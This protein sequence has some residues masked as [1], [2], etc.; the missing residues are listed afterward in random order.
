MLTFAIRRL[1]Q[2]VV[3]LFIMSAL[4]F[5]AVYA[6]GNPI[7]ILINPQADQAEIAAATK[8]LGLDQPLW[9]Q[10]RNFIVGAF[11]G[12]F[13]KSFSANIPGSQWPCGLTIGSP[14]VCS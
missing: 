5:A 7:D 12:D 14:C 10:Y 1:L 8:A 4:V 6:I 13:G 11:T 2:S 3:V 9:L